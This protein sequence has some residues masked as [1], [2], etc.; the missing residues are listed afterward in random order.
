M[1]FVPGN[2]FFLCIQVSPCDPPRPEGL[3]LN[4]AQ[5]LGS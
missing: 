1:S 5:H 3:I 4:G 2:L